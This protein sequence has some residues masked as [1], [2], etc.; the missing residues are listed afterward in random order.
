[1][2]HQLK[3]ASQ[4]IHIGLKKSDPTF[5]SVVTPIYPS[6]TFQFPSAHE[7]A[8][9]FCGKKKGLIYSRFTNPTVYAL[10]KKLAAL[11]NGERALAT[12]SGM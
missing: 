4:N 12:S 2:K 8:L 5:G 1:M 7:G 11:E 3:F 6:S 9:R 10:E